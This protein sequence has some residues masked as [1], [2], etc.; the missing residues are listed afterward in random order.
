M[1]AQGSGYGCRSHGN[2]RDFFVGGFDARTICNWRCVT[3]S[4]LGC[5]AAGIWAPIAVVES[6]R[7]KFNHSACSGLQSQDLVV[8]GVNPSKTL[9]SFQQFGLASIYGTR[10][11]RWQSV[12]ADEIS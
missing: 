10:C 1:V 3:A 6:C 12:L 9:T 7:L 5:L 2:G 4:W 8:E 11:T